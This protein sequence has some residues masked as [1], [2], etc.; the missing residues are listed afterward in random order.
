MKGRTPKKRTPKRKTAKRGI[1]KRR[2]S[3]AVRV[4]M[5]MLAAIRLY[6]WNTRSFAQHKAT[7][8]LYEKMDANIDRFVEVMLGKGRVQVELADHRGRSVDAK[9]AA[10]FASK[11]HEYR[12]FLIDMSA[13]FDKKEDADL[14]SIRDEILGDVNQF[15]Y[16]MSFDK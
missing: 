2:V 15:L 13:Y 12:A 7:D 11:I 8:E 9:G 6:H 10:S 3:H 4:L 5:E 16:L 1:G 14:L